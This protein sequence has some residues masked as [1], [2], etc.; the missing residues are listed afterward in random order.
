MTTYADSV[1]APIDAD[2]SL[3]RVA[4]GNETEVYSSDD[5]R[6]VAKLK[7]ELGGSR[8]DAL[9]AARE[10][11]AAA[12]AFADCLGPRYSIHSHY[13]LARD[14]AGRV[15]ILVLQPYMRHARALCAVDYRSLSREA[16]RQLAAELRAIIARAEAMHRAEGSMPDLYGRTSSSSAERRR[17]RSPLQIPRRLWSFLVERTLLHS[18]NLMRTDDPAQPVVLV[19]YD[20]V[21]RGPLYR[22]VYY[23]VRRALFWR[24]RLVI[25]L[26]L[27]A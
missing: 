11:R 2:L 6:F 9:A 8:D 7:L 26:T 16:R 22:A 10:M 27:G 14:S 20:Y 15:Q 12:E 19:D 25:L 23:L 1:F 24:D 3:E 17:N 4:G 21:R 13:L 18:Q 5:G